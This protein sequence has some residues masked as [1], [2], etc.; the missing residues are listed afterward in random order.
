[1]V[2]DDA[3]KLIAAGM[4]YGMVIAD[5]SNSSHS[6]LDQQFIVGLCYTLIN[7]DLPLRQ[8]V[9]IFVVNTSFDFIRARGLSGSY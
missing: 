1:M 8:T 4:Y 2:P 7:E 9:T 6:F 3:L 5:V